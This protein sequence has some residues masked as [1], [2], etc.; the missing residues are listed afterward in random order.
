M[1]LDI[2]M[3]A[4]QS[5][6]ERT[7]V[8]EIFA[9]SYKA[10]YVTSKYMLESDFYDYNEHND[11]MPVNEFFKHIPF[12]T[13]AK[14]HSF[15][16]TGIGH[17]KGT[18]WISFR[19]NIKMNARTKAILINAIPGVLKKMN[20]DSI[21]EWKVP[22]SSRSSSAKKHPIQFSMLGKTISDTG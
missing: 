14:I 13:S 18:I 3:G 7:P 2:K 9:C 21:T 16:P 11:W 15:L 5:R 6:R 8:H 4:V 12:I 17:T 19:T 20:K 1:L 22:T 10:S